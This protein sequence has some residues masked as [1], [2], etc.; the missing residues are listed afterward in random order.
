MYVSLQNRLF[1][2]CSCSFIPVT[3]FRKACLVDLYRRAVQD[4]VRSDFRR[5]NCSNADNDGL[6]PSQVFVFSE[7][8]YF[9]Q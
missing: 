8:V 2:A 5:I 3:C 9:G 6:A 7:L 4:E 1:I